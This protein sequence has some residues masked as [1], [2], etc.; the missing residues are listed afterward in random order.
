VIYGLQVFSFSADKWYRHYYGMLRRFDEW[1]M[2]KASHKGLVKI[3]ILTT[4]VDL[5]NPVIGH[6]QVEGRS[7]VEDDGRLD[8]MGAG[9]HSVGLLLRLAPEMSVIALK[10]TDTLPMEVDPIARVSKISLNRK[11][12]RHDTK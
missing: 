4:G 12:S 6:G 7:F 9:T 5:T 11:H 8:S 3:A 1:G 2:N 10:I